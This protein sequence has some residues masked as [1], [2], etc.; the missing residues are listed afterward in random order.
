MSSESCGLSLVLFDEIEKAAPSM[1]RLLLGLPV[2][3]ASWALAGFYS[4]LGPMLIRGILGAGSALL[5]GLALFVLAASAGS[6]FVRRSVA[7][8]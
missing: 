4:S 8:P 7:S 1:T 3:V 5:G 2:L 6:A